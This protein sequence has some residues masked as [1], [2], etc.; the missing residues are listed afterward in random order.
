MK[1]I[2][3]LTSYF[4]IF[5][6]IISFL[7]VQHYIGNKIIFFVYALVI[8]FFVLKSFGYKGM[9]FEK[10]I[11]M[12]VWFGFWFKLLY[13]L[14]ITGS[15]RGNLGRFDYSQ[16]LYDKSL[17]VIIVAISSLIF[18]SYLRSLFFY[19]KLNFEFYENK[20]ILEFYKKNRRLIFLIFSISFSILAILN[21]QFNIYRKGLISNLELNFVILGLFK[22]L[23]IFGFCSISSF[24]L[25]YEIRIKKNIYIGFF[26]SSL[27][28]MVTYTGFLSRAMIFNL[29]SLI[30]GIEKLFFLNKKKNRF[31][32]IFKLLII[33]LIFFSI[34]IYFVTQERTRIYSK[35]VK[36]DNSI[37]FNER[38]LFD[39]VNAN[40]QTYDKLKQ[41]K[42]LALKKEKSISDDYP[43]FHNYIYLFFNRFIG[44]EPV[45]S[46]V[47]NPDLGSKIV[48]DSLKEKF[49][50]KK[51]SFY[52]RIFLGKNVSYNINYS[53]NIY[54]M[55]LPGF[56]AF[57]FYSGS[58]I[59]LIT[60]MFIFYCF[61][62]ILEILAYKFSDKNLI[63]TALIGQVIGYRLIHFGYLPSQ[64]YLLILSILFNIFIYFLV[65][66]Y[67][68]NKK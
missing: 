28:A 39:N 37:S 68:K 55:I 56:I 12:F 3:N 15:F 22:W 44:I 43:I 32:K 36:I 29:L 67:F 61:C 26:L 58:F 19:Y 40:N 33:S 48:K 20:N 49:D 42:D 34:S 18:F 7:G 23:T 6:V 2:F 64:T 41:K 24:I 27:E 65:I 11:S 51:Y 53:S 62:L 38:K 60:S 30:M 59:W 35:E 1:K 16:G 13:T 57:S 50:P 45:F 54:G 46:V 8:N 66:N 14:I 25:F 17:V 4:I 10:V 9:F 21:Y 5:N 47:S 52:E 31:L 63:F